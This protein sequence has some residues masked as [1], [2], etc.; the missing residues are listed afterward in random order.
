MSKSALAGAIEAPRRAVLSSR[1]D[2]DI[3]RTHRGRA[4]RPSCRPCAVL[5]VPGIRLGL[6]NTVTLIAL[7]TLGPVYALA[8]SFVRVIL[9][10]VLFG[11]LT[12]FIYSFSGAILA[13]GGMMLIKR[14]GFSV[15]SVSVTGAVAHNSAQ[16]IAAS[17]LIGSRY[18]LGYL[19]VLILAGVVSG[20][21]TGY[22]CALINKRLNGF[23]VIHE[24]EGKR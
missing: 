12:S 7:Y 19:P 23:S 4:V 22:L 5:P 2:D 18:V 20:M 11:S 6:A 16:I 8:V 3:A 15:Y 1:H 9:S 24:S 10:A 13:F 17:L 21:L 14:C